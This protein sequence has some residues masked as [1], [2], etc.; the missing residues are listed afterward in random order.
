[1][2]TSVFL[3]LSWH[4]VF[5]PSLLSL[6]FIFIIHCQPGSMGL[7]LNRFNFGTGHDKD[8]FC[9]LNLKIYWKTAQNSK[10]ISLD[11]PLSCQV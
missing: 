11:G 6:D 1:M 7:N 4:K 9:S 5:L 8:Y 3:L 10:G 2:E